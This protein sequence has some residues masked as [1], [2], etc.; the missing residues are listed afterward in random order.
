MA[1]RRRMATDGLAERRYW[2]AAAATIPFVVPLIGF[3]VAAMTWRGPVAGDSVAGIVWAILL[4]A[5]SFGL[6]PYGGLVLLLLLLLRREDGARAVR[7]WLWAAPFLYLALFWV[8]WVTVFGGEWLSFVPIGGIA[9]AVACGYM[10]LAA[11]GWS[12][13]GRPAT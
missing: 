7:R 1:N 8:M 11:L 9:F 13:W 3:I 2:I 5:V 10:H 4:G 6:P 12:R